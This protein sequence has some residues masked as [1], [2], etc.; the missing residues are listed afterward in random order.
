M[1]QRLSVVMYNDSS[2]IK[3]S[4]CPLKHIYPVLKFNT[5]CK[6]C[7]YV[8]LQFH[9]MNKDQSVYFGT[10]FKSSILLVILFSNEL[11]FEN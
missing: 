10:V 1:I 6:V 11:N 8:E 4:Y 3:F 9:F 7:I 5:G 2:R